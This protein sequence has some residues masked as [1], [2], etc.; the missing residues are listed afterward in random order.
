MGSLFVVWDLISPGAVPHLFVCQAMLS[1]YSI[2]KRASTLPETAFFSCG[3]SWEEQPRMPRRLA[4]AHVEE[5]FCGRTVSIIDKAA[6]G[7]CLEPSPGSRLCRSCHSLFLHR[8]HLQSLSHAEWLTEVAL[9]AANAPALVLAQMEQD[10]SFAAA[11]VARAPCLR[12]GMGSIVLRHL[13]P[14]DQRGPPEVQDLLAGP[15]VGAG[16]LPLPTKDLGL[17]S[18]GADMVQLLHEEEDDL[19]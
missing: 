8:A 13:H 18:L 14:A 1:V 19:L 16:P 9:W 17:M 7:A 15:T 2:P 5:P 6:K 11:I 3:V 4:A 10:P 12:A